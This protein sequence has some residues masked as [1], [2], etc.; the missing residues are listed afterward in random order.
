[1]DAFEWKGDVVRAL[2][3]HVAEAASVVLVSCHARFFAGVWSCS[4]VCTVCAGTVN[5]PESRVRLA[6]MHPHL[7]VVCFRAVSLQAQKVAGLRYRS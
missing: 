2:H 7:Q 3:G 1:M 5:L 6:C 4:S